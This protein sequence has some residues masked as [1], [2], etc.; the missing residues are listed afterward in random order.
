[1]AEAGHHISTRGVHREKPSARSR[2][3]VTDQPHRNF[4]NSPFRR[5]TVSRV[6]HRALWPL[7]A[8]CEAKPGN[9]SRLSPAVTVVV[10]SDR[11]YPEYLCHRY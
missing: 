2:R 7:G 4:R 1:M 5:P 9:R 6:V 10:G 8:S 11:N 3:F